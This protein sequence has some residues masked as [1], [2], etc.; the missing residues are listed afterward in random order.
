[1]VRG[2]LTF[3]LNAKKSFYLSAGP[4]FYRVCSK[5]ETFE[6]PRSHVVILGGPCA[7]DKSWGQM[8]AILR[9]FICDHDLV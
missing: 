6:S 3:P 4:V 2:S 1:M 7:V 9:M 8:Y 5:I